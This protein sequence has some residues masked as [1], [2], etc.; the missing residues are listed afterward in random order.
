MTKPIVYSKKV[1]VAG[2]SNAEVTFWKKVNKDGPIHPEFGQCWQWLGG[3]YQCT[4]K[5][6]TVLLRIKI[7]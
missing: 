6:S 7:W 2:K 1:I 3:K 5:C 4:G